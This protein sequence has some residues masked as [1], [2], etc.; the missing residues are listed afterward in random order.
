MRNPDSKHGFR[1]TGFKPHVPLFAV[2]VRPLK[3]RSCVWMAGP[4]PNPNHPGVISGDFWWGKAM[5]PRLHCC[6]A[7]L[8]KGNL[9]AWWSGELWLHT[10]E[11]KD[12]PI[13]H[14]QIGK[15]GKDTRPE[16]CW[17]TFAP[18]ILYEW[19]D[20][21]SQNRK[22]I[23]MVNLLKP[24]LQPHCSLRRRQSRGQSQWQTHLWIQLW[25]CLCKSGYENVDP[26]S[27]HWFTTIFRFTSWMPSIEGNYSISRHTQISSFCLAK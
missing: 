16:Y 1:P 2:I 21:N 17:V 27:F 18:A 26:P 10:G 23:A 6:R 9:A 25:L 24:C 7:K 13:F 15:I 8:Y 20:F 19:I 11:L 4:R 14:G 5:V 22:H 3:K 12:F